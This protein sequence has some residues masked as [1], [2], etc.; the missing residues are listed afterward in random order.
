MPYGVVYRG[1]LGPLSESLR[2]AQPKLSS[3]DPLVPQ[4]VAVSGAW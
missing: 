2:V 4:R 1:L 3:P